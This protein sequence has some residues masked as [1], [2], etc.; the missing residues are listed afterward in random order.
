MYVVQRDIYDIGLSYKKPN[1]SYIY[2]KSIQL[3]VLI[4]RV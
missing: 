3:I 4:G 1:L 2:H